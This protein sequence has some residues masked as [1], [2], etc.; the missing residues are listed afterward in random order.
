MGRLDSR[1]AESRLGGPLGSGVVR[2]A[3]LFHFSL[4]DSDAKRV[5]HP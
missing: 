5:P 2:S 4:I 1:H 3:L